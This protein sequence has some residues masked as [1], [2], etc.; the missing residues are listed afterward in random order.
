MN[1]L[2]WNCRGLGLPRTVRVLG[3]LIRTHK[4]KFLFL[5]ETI[6]Y[7]NK[8][9]ELRVKFGFAQCFSVDRVG[10]SGGLAIFWRNNVN[11]EVT[12]YSRNHVNVNFLNNGA[13]VWSPS[14]FYG[15]PESDRMR[16]SWNIIRRLADVAQIPW[17]IIAEISLQGGS[18]TWEKF[19]GT[20]D[21]VKERLDRAFATRSW[22]HSFP[23]C[24]L[25]VIRTSVS[26]HDLIL[27]DLYSLDFTQMEFQFRFENTWLQEPNFH[28]KTSDFWLSL[29][30]SHIIPK[31]ISVSNFMARWGRTFFTSFAT[32]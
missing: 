17:V 28:K 2:S 23:M 18:F 24:K 19:R 12:S 32:K 3:D 5:S 9:E 11:C 10:R 20:S 15:C 30:P 4:P 8:V 21:W 1:V 13:A 27:L 6:S 14:C 26:D 31:L 7:A 29:P 25:S 16:T 22:P